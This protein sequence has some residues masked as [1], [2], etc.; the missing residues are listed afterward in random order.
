M[1]Q[2]Y[3][4]ASSQL[5][6]CHTYTSNMNTSNMS[7]RTACGFLQIRAHLI[8]SLAKLPAYN[9]RDAGTRISG[10]DAAALAP[11]GIGNVDRKLAPLA[12]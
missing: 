3:L 8:M 1:V 2:I 9:A 6:L 11:W 4:V 10:I 7:G 12:P 5:N